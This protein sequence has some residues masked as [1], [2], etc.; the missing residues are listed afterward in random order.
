MARLAGG[1]PGSGNLLIEIVLRPIAESAVDQAK[2]M[3]D[4]GQPRHGFGIR[5]LRLWLVLRDEIE[6]PTGLRP[7]KLIKV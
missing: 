2:G 6:H 7:T 5:R 1:R 3:A 4:A